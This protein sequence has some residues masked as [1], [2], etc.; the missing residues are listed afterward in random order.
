MLSQNEANEK[1]CPFAR[2]VG[3]GGGKRFVANRV[4][5]QVLDERNMIGTTCLGPRC[6][7][8]RWEDNRHERGYC[9]MAGKPVVP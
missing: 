4:N 9:G 7:A 2:T 8:W 3:E 1:W 5:D 6:M